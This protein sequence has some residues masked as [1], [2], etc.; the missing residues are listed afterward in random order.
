[1]SVMQSI[2]VS[3]EPDALTQQPFPVCQ[4]VSGLENSIGATS[5]IGVASTVWHCV[6]ELQP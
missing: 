3:D 5:L 4:S 1:M 2:L 6:A